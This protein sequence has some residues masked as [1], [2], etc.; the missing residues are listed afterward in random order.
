MSPIH[1]QAGTW[2]SWKSNEFDTLYCLFQ[3]SF[4]F[5]TH[6]QSTGCELCFTRSFQKQYRTVLCSLF[7]LFA[8]V[9]RPT[10]RVRY[11][12]QQLT[13]ASGCL[14]LRSPIL[15]ASKRCAIFS[16]IL[17]QCSPFWPLS[18]RFGSIGLSIVLRARISVINPASISIQVI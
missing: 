11:L 1:A 7:L 14:S 2:N 12:Q 18:G 16:Y 10:D 17:T 9:S 8:M 4:Y 3:C 6:D 13:H 15:E 5:Q